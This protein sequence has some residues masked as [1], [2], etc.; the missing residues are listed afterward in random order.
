M[1][2][3]RIL[4]LKKYFKKN[5][6][7]MLTYGDG[8]TNQNITDLVKFHK[9]HNKIVTM[10]VVKPPATLTPLTDVSAWIPPTEATMS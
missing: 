4:K 8:L 5:E 7:F 2:G 3:G 6:N 9:K 10:T 1:T